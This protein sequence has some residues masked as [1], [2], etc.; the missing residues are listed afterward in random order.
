MEAPDP[1]HQTAPA[2][3][4][5]SLRALLL[6]L[7]LVLV[8]C[9]GAP[10]SIWMVGSSEITWSYFPIG[11]GVPL[12]LLLAVNALVRRWWP[13]GGLTP[14]ELITVIIMGLVTSGI[15]IFMAGYLLAIP[16][17][18]YYG[19]TPENEW[20]AYIQPYLP[21][22][23]IPGGS[24]ESMRFFYEGLPA[25]ASIPWASWLA[26]LGWWLSL[27]LA[28]YLACF[29]LVIILRRQ[30]V[31]HE[32]LAF[33]LTEMSRLLVEEKPGAAL[34]PVLTS[35]VFW[36]GWAVPFSIIAF[37][38]IGYFHPGF[39][40]VGVHQGLALQWLD[41]VPA[42]QVLL[43][44]PIVGFMYLV[45]TSISFSIW[46]FFLFFQ[47]EMGLFNWVGLT[48]TPDA[49]VW[50]P[51]PALSWQ[52]FGAFTTMVLLS[53]WMARGHLAAVL[54]QALRGDAQIDDSGEMVSYRTAVYG[55]AGG[56]LYLLA[57]LWRS[58]MDLHIAALFL[59]G[60]LVIYLGI[61]RLVIQSGMYY[62]TTP[63]ASQGLVL[64]ITGTAVMPPNLVAL[65]LSY[66]W[67]G[68]IQSL[69]MPS[70]A[71]AARL[72]QLHRGRRGLGLAIALAVVVGFAVTI[73]FMLYLCYQY[74]AGNFRSWI[75][76]PGA[77]AG[78]IAFDSAVRHMR[79]PVDTD[80][81]KLGYFSLGSI[82]YGLLSL[83][84]YRFYWW[85]LHPVGLTIS[86]V[87]MI[88]RIAFSVFLSWAVKSL[89]LRLGG[90]QLY[91]Q[92]RPFFIG[93][94]VGFFTGIGLSYAIDLIW[95]FGKG[96]AILHG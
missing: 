17:K 62:L 3:S 38:T 50:G 51:S 13:G 73:C 15:P 34:P 32:R 66:S 16:S 25:G 43:Y 78:G 27:L 35:R 5:L 74:G 65:A 80:W 9:L 23:A 64:A 30:W 83:G 11:V 47:V 96:H 26:P 20:A 54:R 56:C 87:W 52:G 14:P 68:D 63:M 22:W 48:A 4:A 36:I 90:V 81:G 28:L 72:N 67:H 58:G 92:I 29:C 57:W 49:F 85:P 24:A 59:F 93:L 45:G 82:L 53:L 42:V 76:Q 21:E 69:F 61:T 70:A 60:V 12:V 7:V 1:S 55:F 84:H 19:A 31:E 88:Q 10:F 75:F 40:Q 79:N 46:F 44:F 37:N 91:R 94:I 2:R 95:F 18:P 89:V 33:P 6:G 71:H 86:S 41:G 77:G 8:I 39:P